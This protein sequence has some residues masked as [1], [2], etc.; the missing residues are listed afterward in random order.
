MRIFGKNT[1]IERLK[2]NPRSIKKIY[3]QQRHP[4]TFYVQKKGKKWGVPV[5]I[6]PQSKILK[7]TRNHNSQGIVADVEDFTYTDYNELIELS[8]KKKL[9]LLFLDNLQDPQNLGS[10][11]RSLACFGDFAIVLP[12]KESVGVT[13]S[14]FRV[15]SGGD[16]YVLIA[17]VANLSNAISVAK[18][19]GFWIIGAVVGEGEDLSTIS[20]PFSVALVVGSEEK[21]IRDV[22]KK[23]LDVK[24]T[25]PMKQPRLSFN[26]AHATTILCYEITKQKNQKKK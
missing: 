3:I 9:S 23:H 8:K 26:A 18:K 25:I 12:K 1:V 19:N 13:E 22:V 4:D 16:N 21:G 17:R 14:V 10:I 11:I 7:I 20:L 6:V 2:S 24:I 15:A 5:Y